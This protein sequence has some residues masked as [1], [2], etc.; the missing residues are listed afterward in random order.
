MR[1]PTI[2]LFVLIVSGLGFSSVGWAESAAVFPKGWDTWPITHSGAIP[3][4]KTKIPTDLPA[5]VKETFKTYNWIQDGKGSAYN[6]RV[7]PRQR[8]A[9]RS[10]KSYEDGPSAVL[11]LTDIKVLLVTE[12]LL[13]EPQYGVFS[14]DGKDLSAAHPSLDP[15]ACNNCH[16]G[17]K[18]ICRDGICSR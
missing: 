16:S 13:G 9:Q 6:V 8:N 5:I 10:G 4:N 12:H 14:Y 11:E 18:E 7:N 1:M 15:K 3:G 17:Y 2:S